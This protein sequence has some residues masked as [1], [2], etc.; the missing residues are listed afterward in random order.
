M[1]TEQGAWNPYVAGALSGLLGV[2]SVVVAGKFMGASTTFVRA[3]GMIEKM[4]VPET[5]AN[6]AYY[7]SKGLQF[8]WQ[9]LFVIGICI[10]S[11]I[12]SL[13]SKTFV[14]QAVPTMWENRHG[15]SVARR[16]VVAFVGGMVAMYG[17]RLAGGCPSG[18]GLSGL[19]QLSVSGF[20]AA[21]C[22]FAGGMLMAALVFPRSRQE[23]HG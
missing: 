4:F 7:M 23:R 20:I 11:L 22:F 17:A 16:G 3:S 5:V 14:W 19:T 1:K 12:A 18:H 9:F 15:G 21:A 13:T 6:T 8:D 10:G 2:F